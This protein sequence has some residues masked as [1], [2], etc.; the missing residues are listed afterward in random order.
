AIEVHGTKGAHGWTPVQVFIKPFLTEY[1]WFSGRWR[2]FPLVP[3]AGQLRADHKYN[4]L[5]SYPCAIFETARCDESDYPAYGRKQLRLPARGAAAPTTSLCPGSSGSE[6]QV[7]DVLLI[8]APP[9]V[10]R[11]AGPARPRGM[12]PGIQQA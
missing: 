8:P 4:R 9:S 3:G 6:R 11:D 5:V 7:R 12:A 10:S 1:W 2:K